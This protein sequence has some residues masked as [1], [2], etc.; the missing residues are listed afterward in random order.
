MIL[1]ALLSSC[2]S[3]Y[4]KNQAMMEAVYD[5]RYV[6]ADKILDN[7][8][9]RKKK[10][11]ILL[12]YLNRG[13]V[14]WLNQNYSESNKYFQQADFY[15][16]DVQRNYG[17]LALGLVTNPSMEPYKGE[18]FEQ[19]LLHYFTTLNY[20]Q[21]GSLDDALIECKRMQ[22]KM[23][24][25]TDTYGGKNSYKRDA[26]ADVLLGIIYDAQKD[27]N[28]AFIAYRNALEIYN[29]DYNPFLAT[30]VPTQLKKDII[31]TAYLSGFK[32]EAT[33]YEEMFGIDYHE[34]KMDSSGTLV[35]FWNNGLGP[36]KDEW[37]INLFIVP[38]GGNVV[39]F[40]NP[41]LNLRF[42]YSVSDEDQKND[43]TK[44]K[45][46][47]IAFPKYITRIPVFQTAKLFSDS[48]HTSSDFDLV[49]PINSIAYKS[50]NDRMLREFGEALLRVALKQLA[51]AEVAKKNEG[52][53]AAV[54]I[55][56]AFTE[57]AD[58]RNWQLL[59]YSINYTRTILPVGK[60]SLILQLKGASSGMDKK[61]DVIIKP[62][63]TSFGYYQDYQF[64]GYSGQ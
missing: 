56:N 41:D 29:K 37:S 9:L 5:G 42:R 20:L 54:G 38:D 55:L 46:I 23:Q 32:D 14:N 45:V 22:L 60:Q 62:N 12:Y 10:R 30:P 47:R 63:E 25:I 59:P 51:E 49:E 15:I 33:N 35:Y 52:L 4:E 31:R 57:Q 16:E 50:L 11:D 39:Y 13:T 24:R 18:G 58:T 40:E 6:D 36:V 1:L 2:A 8:S 48:L 17:Y 27:Y 34:D 19:I 28:N 7:P 21:L 26:F 43:L 44:L 64:M 53:G 61:I 3:Y